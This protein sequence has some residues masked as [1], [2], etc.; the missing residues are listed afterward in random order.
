MCLEP[1]TPKLRALKHEIL[2]KISGLKDQEIILETI[3]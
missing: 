2:R 3:T 1:K